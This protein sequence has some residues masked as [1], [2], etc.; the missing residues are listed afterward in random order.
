MTLYQNEFRV[1]STRLRNWD[2]RSRGWFFVTI[3]AHEKAHIFGEIIKCE[4]ELSPIGRIVESDLQSLSSHYEK[5]QL[6]SHIVMPNHVHAIIMLNGDHSYSPDPT[7]LAPAMG[8]SPQAASLSAIVRSYKAGVTRQCHD[9]RLRQAIWQSRFHDKLL[10]S[11]AVISAVRE[12]IW[13]N[14]ANWADDRE[15]SI[16]DFLVET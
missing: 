15:N 13:N 10:R 8:I 7:A 14:P 12:Y 1:E 5:V 2:Y 4:V 9:L 6:D 3:C 11:D 16:P